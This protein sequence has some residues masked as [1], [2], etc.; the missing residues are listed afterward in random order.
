[1]SGTPA[2][3]FLLTRPRR[4]T[5]TFQTVNGDGDLGTEAL[6]I[7]A[8]NIVGRLL[9]V[10][11]TFLFGAGCTGTGDILAPLPLGFVPADIDPAGMPGATVAP[12]IDA[13]TSGV[14]AIVTRAPAPG[15][16]SEACVVGGY[17]ST[18][19]DPSDS[20]QFGFATPLAIVAGNGLI[21]TYTLPLNE[22]AL[23]G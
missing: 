7:G 23:P 16:A 20:L 22:P 8:Y 5:P 14:L 18:P 19:P 3:P 6:A 9:T 12:G 4:F 11:I 15:P 17:L 21:A 1:M 13:V 2:D 10:Q